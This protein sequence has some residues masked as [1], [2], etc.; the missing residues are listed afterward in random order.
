MTLPTRGEQTVPSGVPAALEPNFIPRFYRASGRLGE[1][2]GSPAGEF[3]SEEWVGSMTTVF[4]AEPGLGLST[5]PSGRLLRDEVLADP[6]GMLGPEHLAAFGPSTELLVKILDA[7]ERLPVHAHPDRAF[8]ATHLGSAHGKAEAW[9]IL[10]APEDASVYL[11]F[12]R[13]MERAEVLELMATQDS[14][15]LLDAMHRLPVSVGDSVFVPAGF[16][17]AIGAGILLVELQEPTDYS[18]L[19]EWKGYDLDPERDGRLGLE[20][21]VALGAVNRSGIPADVIEG[22]RR[23]A[24]AVSEGSSAL[25]GPEAAPFFRADR[26]ADGDLLEAGF[27]IIVVTSGELSLAAEG[28]AETRYRAGAAVLVP[29]AAGRIRVSGDGDAIRARPPLVP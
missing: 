23:S 27:S 6:V 24:G 9:I 25:F 21:E 16:P 7:G 22:L 17:H 14:E 28:G 8:A 12:R 26:L 18:M 20:R 4:G 5:L 2:R 10:D 15:A 19:L 3:D 11:G 13:P 1:F 29:H